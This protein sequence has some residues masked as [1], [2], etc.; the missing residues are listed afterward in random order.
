MTLL[1]TVKLYFTLKYIQIQLYE[2]VLKILIAFQSIPFTFT[3][4]S[5]VHV[6]FSF[7]LMRI[8]VKMSPLWQEF[9][10]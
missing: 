5:A 7:K 10:H 1:T 3:K 8:S 4:D 2:K 9:V 6:T